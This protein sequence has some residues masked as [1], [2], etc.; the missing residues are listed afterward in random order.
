M[1]AC[2][3]R[4]VIYMERAEK[5]EKREKNLTAP[6]GRI[7]SPLLAAGK[8]WT[9]ERHQPFMSADVRGEPRSWTEPAIHGD[10]KGNWCPVFQG[11]H[12]NSSCSKKVTGDRTPGCAKIH[13]ST[14]HTIKVLLV[15]TLNCPGWTSVGLGSLMVWWNVQFPGCLH[16]GCLAAS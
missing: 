5:E 11:C 3:S 15:K 12:A 6:P 4:E 10:C 9:W 1:K 13:I 8:R 14:G 2:Y 7:S 16:A